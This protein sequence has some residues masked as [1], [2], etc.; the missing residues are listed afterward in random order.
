MQ[1]NTD[2]A[3]NQSAIDILY[4]AVGS[5][6]G[7]TKTF[8]TGP[9]TAFAK[10][11][12]EKMPFADWD[13]IRNNPETTL[14]M[15]AAYIFQETIA[16][17]AKAMFVGANLYYAS[18]LFSTTITV[19]VVSVA[20]VL[21][22]N[23]SQSEN[24]KSNFGKKF[25]EFYTTVTAPVDLEEVVVAPETEIKKEQLRFEINHFPTMRKEDFPDITD[26]QFQMGT[27]LPGEDG[28]HYLH[29]PPRNDNDVALPMFDV[30]KSMMSR[31]MLSMFDVGFPM[32]NKQGF[33]VIESAALNNS[34]LN[35]K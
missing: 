2:I 34:T 27:I 30:S 16:T 4:D 23:L 31:P 6:C 3:A 15:K 35:P 19:L 14:D 10:A 13:S 24:A 28:K 22:Y 11:I 8:I 18:V 32:F 17:L 9:F 26:Y 33:P 29:V 21:L 5:L 12:P 1:V 20:S 25:S 7:H